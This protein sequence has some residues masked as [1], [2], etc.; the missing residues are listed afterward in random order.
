MRA[1]TLLTNWLSN[2]PKTSKIVT[3]TI[4]CGEI[5]FGITRL[6][7][8]KRRNELELAAGMILDSIPCEPVPAKAGDYY[9]MIKLAR[10]RSGLALDENDLWIA[11]TALTLGATLVSRDRDFSGITGLRVLTLS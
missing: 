2:L 5:L 6:N 1:N 7:E 9:A 10:Q 11:A 3:C 8:G 4:V